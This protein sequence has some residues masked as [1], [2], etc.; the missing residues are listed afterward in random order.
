MPQKKVSGVK[1]IR[2]SKCQRRF[3]YY[4]ELNLP[5]KCPQCGTD[6][7]RSSGNVVRKEDFNG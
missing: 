7:S 3:K 4:E 6:S 5:R 2:C 1:I